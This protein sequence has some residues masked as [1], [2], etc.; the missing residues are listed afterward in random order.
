MQDKNIYLHYLNKNVI[1]VSIFTLGKSKDS[2]TVFI[3]NSNMLLLYFL[4][5]YHISEHKT[6]FSKFYMSLLTM[7]QR[8]STFVTGLLESD[9]HN[10]HIKA[11]D[12]ILNSPFFIQKRVFGKE[13]ESESSY[14]NKLSIIKDLQRYANIDQIE[15]PL[16]PP[17]NYKPTPQLVHVLKFDYSKSEF[18]KLS[19]KY[20]KL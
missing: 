9:N 11:E 10:D 7:V 8:V 6:I 12:I 15:L 13:N 16:I 18:F 19:G 14:Y 1:P 17:I 5:Y 2:Y 4:L 3:P 20:I